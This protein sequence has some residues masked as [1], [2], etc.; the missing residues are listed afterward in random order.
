MEKS[1]VQVDERYYTTSQAAELL[2]VDDDKILAMIRTN[3]IRAYDVSSS[4]SSRPR[5]RIAQTDLGVF[6]LSRVSKPLPVLAPK[7][8]RKEREVKDYFPE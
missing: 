2:G 7:R 1:A 4:S 3:E 6:L 8:K 5:W